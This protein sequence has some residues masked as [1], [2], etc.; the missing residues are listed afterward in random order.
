MDGRCFDLSHESGRMDQSQV[1]ESVHKTGETQRPPQH[2]Q[3]GR[4]KHASETQE[5]TC[6]RVQ[7]RDNTNQAHVRNILTIRVLT[8]WNDFGGFGIN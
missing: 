6:A 5:R 3:K 7:V 4:R 2:G 8:N 1:V